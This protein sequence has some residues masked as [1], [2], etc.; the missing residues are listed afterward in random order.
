[1]LVMRLP[2]KCVTFAVLVQVSRAVSKLKAQLLMQL[3]G[4]FPVAEDI[5]RQLL[6]LGRR[7]SAAEL[8]VRL[9]AI[10]AKVVR[11]VAMDH[12]YNCELSV[13][14]M[15]PIAELPDYQQLMYVIVHFLLLVF[16]H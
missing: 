16:V 12:L 4:T 7:M 14:A 8:F 6:T 11:Q 9:Y 3:D 13:A 10:D 1:M 2:F 5:G 15:G